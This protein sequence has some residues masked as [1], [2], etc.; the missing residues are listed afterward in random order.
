MLLCIADATNQISKI[1]KPNA[2]WSCRFFKKISSRPPACYACVSKK[3][4]YFCK[5]ALDIYNRALYNYATGMKTSQR[6]LYNDETRMQPIACLKKCLACPQKSPTSS[7]S[8]PCIS[9]KVPLM[10]AVEP[11]KIMKRECD[12]LFPP[13]G[14]YLVKTALFIRKR[15]QDA[16]V[17]KS[18]AQWWNEYVTCCLWHADHIL[19][20]ELYTF[21]KVP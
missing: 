17:Q 7:T 10:Y 9:T 12:L 6:A 1:D 18:P 8:E 5:R 11:C 3:S 19:S 14:E 20:T 13:Y 21:T 15:A 16:Y 2:L 4:M